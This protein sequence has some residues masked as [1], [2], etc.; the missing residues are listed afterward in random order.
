MSVLVLSVEAFG[1]K[2]RDRHPFARAGP[3]TNVQK[4]KPIHSKLHFNW[5]SNL[6]SLSLFP[7]PPPP[8]RHPRRSPPSF[9]TTPRFHFLAR[10]AVAGILGGLR[11][12]SPVRTLHSASSLQ[13]P[14]AYWSDFSVWVCYA[15]SVFQGS[16]FYFR[17]A[18]QGLSKF[19]HD[20]MQFSSQN[21]RRVTVAV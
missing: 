9:R 18:A 19:H 16:S 14:R 3:S 17:S 21:L 10:A 8:P 4:C 5:H 15:L 6:S 2:T 7:T 20:F 12:P 13:S 1:P 11:V